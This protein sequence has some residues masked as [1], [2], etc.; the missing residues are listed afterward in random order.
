[1]PQHD[2]PSRSSRGARRGLLS[3]ASARRLALVA[4][5]TGVLFG[6]LGA[7]SAQ[8]AAKPNDPATS[9]GDAP[10]SKSCD[11]SPLTTND[12][13]Q[14][15]NTCVAVDSGEVS[16]KTPAVLI[17]SAP[18]QVAAGQDFQVSISSKNVVRDRFL[19]AAT[20]GYYAERSVLNPQGIQRG[21]SHVWV[22]DIGDGQSAPNADAAP[23]DFFKAVEDNGN[24]DFSLTITGLNAGN[25]K[26]CVNDA[27]GSHRTA[28]T[29]AAKLA[30]PYDC[31]RLTVTGGNGGGGGA[32]TTT[33]A[34]E[35]TTTAAPDT[36][37]APE[38]TAAPPDT[39]AAP[40]TTAAPPD[41]QAPETTA[42]QG[43]Q[44]PPATEAP[45]PPPPAQQVN[46]AAPPNSA[47]QVEGVDEA[48][49]S[50]QIVTAPGVQGPLPFTG[51]PSGLLLAVG[52]LLVV[53]GCAFL[54]FTDKRRRP[55]H[56]A[57]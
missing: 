13:F 29:K 51:A 41:T 18:E 39:T 57:R 9:D 50:N 38:T 20:G 49:G 37:A 30:M 36:T 45:P 22:Q 5:V 55:G 53:G 6:L 25:K 19:A 24:G 52:V 12:G 27:D 28:M 35:T 23:L 17:T 47:A 21:H 7:V 54:L 8:E 44:A 43:G 16:D 46:Q 2:A 31:V 40:E 26:L 32:T 34:Q 33:A 11:D 10:L 15:G 3:E 42:Q 56:V 14:K 48:A 1:M 4:I